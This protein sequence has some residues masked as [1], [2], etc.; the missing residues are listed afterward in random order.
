[1]GMAK[2]NEEKMSEFAAVK[3][4]YNTKKKRRN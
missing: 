4:Q 3:A 2:I 1:M